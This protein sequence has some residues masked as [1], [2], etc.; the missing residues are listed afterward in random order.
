MSHLVM[1]IICM[2]HKLEVWRMQAATPLLSAGSVQEYSSM[3]DGLF[4]VTGQSSSELFTTKKT[5][6]CMSA[7]QCMYQTN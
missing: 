2:W 1:L 7:Q 5:K 3:M 4:K 6:L